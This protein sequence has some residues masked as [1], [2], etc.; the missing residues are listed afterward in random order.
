MFECKE[1]MNVRSCIAS[2][3][4][5]V[6]AHVANAFRRVENMNG[7]KMEENAT[8]ERESLFTTMNTILPKCRVPH[9][10]A[11]SGCVLFWIR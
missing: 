3:N 1:M 2:M 7:R 10:M 4:T 6:N 9:A 8:K 5:S 11:G